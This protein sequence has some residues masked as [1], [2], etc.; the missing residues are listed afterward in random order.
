MNFIS[1][2]FRF[3]RNL[4][5]F[6][7]ELSKHDRMYWRMTASITTNSTIDKTAV[8][9][10]NYSLKN[11]KIGYASYVS[12]NANISNTT[13][14]KFCSIG[15]N[16]VSGWGI[17]PINGISTHP[18]FY[19]SIKKSSFTLCETDQFKEASPISVGNDVFI[20]ANVTVLD[21]V[22]IG[23]GA[24]IGAGAVVSK[25]IP[26]YAVAIGCPIKVVKY[27]FSSEEIELLLKLNWWDKDW[28]YKRVK[29]DFFD[30]NNFLEEVSLKEY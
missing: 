30:I 6:L 29:N 2:I 15:P 27:R 26:P 25:D 28:L 12:H 18:A 19:S 22:S 14:G 10:G 5:S 24:V 1:K 13:I 7:S 21:G 9:Y 11:V 17:H 3:L 4:A 8:V 23:D 16:F 20:G